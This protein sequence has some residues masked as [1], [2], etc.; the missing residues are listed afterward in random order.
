MRDGG[1]LGHCTRVHQYCLR[2]RPIVLLCIPCTR[3]VHAQYIKFEIKSYELQND[4]VIGPHKVPTCRCYAGAGGE[5]VHVARGPKAGP[6]RST[7][8][9]AAGELLRAAGNSCISCGVQCLSKPAHGGA[10]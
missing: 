6:W 2:Y 7:N 4:T 5:G 3:H 10:M 9:R 1:Q 8:A